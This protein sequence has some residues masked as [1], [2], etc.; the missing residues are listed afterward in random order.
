M[1]S[2]GAVPSR[3]GHSLEVSL[4]IERATLLAVHIMDIGY[5]IPASSLEFDALNGWGKGVR[6]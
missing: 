1:I 6:T 2:T 3:F 4:S 5:E